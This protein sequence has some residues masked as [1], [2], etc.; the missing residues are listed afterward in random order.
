MTD[1]DLT[2]STAERDVIRGEFMTLFGDGSEQ[3][4]AKIICSNLHR[5]GPW[6]VHDRRCRPLAK[7]KIHGEGVSV[8]KEMAKNCRAFDPERNRFLIDELAHMP[9]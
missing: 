4:Q 7:G 9:D 2:L 5:A 6:I 8:L 3:G 1:S